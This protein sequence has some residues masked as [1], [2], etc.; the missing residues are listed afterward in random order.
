[1]SRSQQFVRVAAFALTFAATGLAAKASNHPAMDAS[2]A[3]VQREWERV[4]YQVKGDR[5]KL[6]RIKAVVPEAD[7]LVARF[8]GRAEPLIWDG[9]IKSEE[10]GKA[11]GL[12][13]LGDA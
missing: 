6:Q 9:I 1:M 13:A 7:A 3:R 2:V 4:A 11:G 5:A 12:E 10:A 8:P